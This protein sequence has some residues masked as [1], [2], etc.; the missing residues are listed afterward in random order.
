MVPALLTTMRIVTQQRIGL[1]LRVRRISDKAECERIWNEPGVQMPFH[2]CLWRR[3]EHP[4]IAGRRVGSFII[5]V[6]RIAH[7]RGKASAQR[8]KM[9]GIR[10]R[11]A[12]EYFDHLLTT[13]GL[14]DARIARMTGKTVDE[15]RRYAEQRKVPIL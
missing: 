1:E 3:F 14:N 12:M 7:P 15:I 6:G 13:E 2:I 11:T 4:A 8:L 10:C 9:T 5:N